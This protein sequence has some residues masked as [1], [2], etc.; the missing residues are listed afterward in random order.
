MVLV[1]DMNT[2]VTFLFISWVSSAPR[3]EARHIFGESSGGGAAGV[4]VVLSKI[5][6]RSEISVGWL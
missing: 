2:G 5:Y 4:Y 6:I 1:S 3:G